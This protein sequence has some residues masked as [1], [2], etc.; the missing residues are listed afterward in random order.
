[1]NE[2]ILK[3]LHVLP[4]D[5]NLIVGVPR[6]GMLPA[7]LIA[8]YLN[9]PYTDIDSFIQ[10]YVYKSGA[11]SQFFDDTSQKKILIVDDSLASGRA[12][13]ECR[14]KLAHLRDTYEIEYCV[15]YSV[16][17]NKNLV[18]YPLEIVST[19]RY[20]QWNI[21]N[22]STLEKACFDIDGVLCIDPTKE[23]NDDGEKYRDFLLNAAPLYIPKSKIG[24]LVTSRLEKYRTETEQWL[25]NHG[26]KYKKLVMLDLPNQKAR[27][28]ANCHG[29]HKAKEFNKNQYVLFVESDVSQAK[30]INRLTKKPVF[31]TENFEMIFESESYIY[32]IK[33]GK[34]FPFL[35]RFALKLRDTLRKVKSN[36]KRK[37]FEV[38]TE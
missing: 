5:F 36:L 27:Q 37:N 29:T 12:L 6:S 11:R 16:P 9:L 1:M 15:I 30:E 21:F 18:E 38:K 22:H 19:P 24:T 26:I 3:K 33:S 14:K 7:N 34:Y 31:C 2:S 20:F 28:Q 25:T 10:G 32:N 8:L 17:E 13:R 23:Q 4:R 35:R